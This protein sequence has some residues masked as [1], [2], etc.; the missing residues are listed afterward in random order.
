MTSFKDHSRYL[1]FLKTK[2]NTFF[3][4]YPHVLHKTIKNYL[5]IFIVTHYKY[6][7]HKKYKTNSVLMFNFDNMFI[8]TPDKY[9]QNLVI[10]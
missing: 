2:F 10:V 5:V 3:K 9:C 8:G 4:K 1:R 6:I 7:K